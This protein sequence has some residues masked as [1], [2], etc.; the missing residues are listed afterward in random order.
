MRDHFFL[1]L[2][3]I[4]GPPN[5]V[6]ILVIKYFVSL[7]KQMEEINQMRNLS[8][9]LLLTVDDLSHKSTASCVFLFVKSDVNEV[10]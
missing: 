1:H 2:L 5:V 9:L 8:T 4:F 10:D 3:W 7:E 6:N